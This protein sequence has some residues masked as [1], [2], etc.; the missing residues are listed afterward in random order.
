MV[1]FAASVLALAG[2]AVDETG[3]IAIF[4]EGQATADGRLGNAEFSSG[5]RDAATGNHLNEQAQVF[6]LS[7][8]FSKSER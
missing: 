3:P 7:Q 6:Y 1:T 4:Q 8:V 5:F 2:R